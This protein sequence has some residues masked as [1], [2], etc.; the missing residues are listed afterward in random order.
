M[1]ALQAL[2]I[3]EKLE[4]VYAEITSRLLVNLAKYFDVKKDTD[5]EQW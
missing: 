5:I 4:M 1:T 3:S 2:E